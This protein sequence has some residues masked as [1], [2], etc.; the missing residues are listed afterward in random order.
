[1]PGPK[2]TP[3]QQRV[4]PA[5]RVFNN[6]GVLLAGIF[7]GEVGLYRSTEDV[8]IGQLVIFIGEE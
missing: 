7:A 1:M 6:F 8:R 2:C 4:P 5:G 3:R